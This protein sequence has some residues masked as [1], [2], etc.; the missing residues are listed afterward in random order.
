M[1]PCALFPYFNDEIVSFTLLKFVVNISLPLVYGEYWIFLFSFAL[2]DILFQGFF[3]CE[4]GVLDIIF[5]VIFNIGRN[6][7]L[8]ER[9]CKIPHVD[10][11]PERNIGSP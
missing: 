6:Y 1:V 8:L 3:S 7:F 4:N 11:I 5:Q 9:F 2:L 10:I